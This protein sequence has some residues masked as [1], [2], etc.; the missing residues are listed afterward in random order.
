MNIAEIADIFET[1]RIA[2]TRF[3][4]NMTKSEMTKTIDLYLET[5]ED[6]EHEALKTAVKE[7][8][9]TSNY[10]PAI[11]E[12]MGELKKAKQKWELVE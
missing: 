10:P 2:Y 5:F 8:I 11:A 3:Y 4:S 9:K 12:M 6:V 7:I 1:L